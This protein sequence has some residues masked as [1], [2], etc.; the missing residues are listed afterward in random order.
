MINIKPKENV[1][2][3]KSLDTEDEGNLGHNAQTKLK[4]D[5]DRGVA[6]I[7]APGCFP[8]RLD[9]EDEPVLVLEPEMEAELDLDLV[10]LL[11]LEALHLFQV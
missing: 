8:E 11:P 10:L 9:A 2:S 5:R 4:N 3:K 6:G 7:G 1:K